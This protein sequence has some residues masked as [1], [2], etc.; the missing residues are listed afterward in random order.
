MAVIIMSKNILMVPIQL[1]ASFISAQEYPSVIEPMAEFSRFPYFDSE[2]YVNPNVANI[3]EEIVSQSFHD[4]E[5][6]LKS[7]CHLHWALPD[8]LTRGESDSQGNIT[9]PIVP[10]RWLIIRTKNDVVQ[11]Q[12]IVESDY[13][14]SPGTS[15]PLNAIVYPYKD[16]THPQPFRYMGRSYELETSITLDEWLQFGDNDSNEFKYLNK[17]YLNKLANDG[18][19]AVGCGEPC[20]AA[21]YPN[22]HSIFSFYDNEPPTDLNGVQYYVIG[23]YSDIKLDCLR[24]LIINSKGLQTYQIL[25]EVL[26]E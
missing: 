14:Y 7:G 25:Q 23:K 3:S 21:F 12:W 13:L 10:D 11:K 1:N 22:C 5:F 8:A 26:Q 19:T 2:R 18:L 9:F 17:L 6:Q 16:S 24:T 4:R 15:V 20:L